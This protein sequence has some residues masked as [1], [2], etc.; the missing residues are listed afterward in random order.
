MRAIQPNTLINGRLGTE[1]D[2]RS[3]GDNAIPPEASTEAWETPATINDTWGF[4][5][6]DTTGSSRDRSRS[7]SWTSSARAATTANV[8]P[9]A[10]AHSAAEQDMLRTV[11]RWLKVNGEAIYGAG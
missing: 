11:G 7:S 4:R 8:G 5:K 6:D 3:T 10:E 9:T 2:Y 1:G